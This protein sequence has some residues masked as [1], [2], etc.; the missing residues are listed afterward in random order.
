M[1]LGDSA[2]Q[3]APPPETWLLRLPELAEAD[4]Q[5]RFR[6]RFVSLECLVGTAE[7]PVYLTIAE[8]RVTEA[9]RGPLLMRPWRFA[10]RATPRAW[11]AFWQ[12]VPCPGWHDLFALTKRGE[13]TIEGEIGPLL[14]N[15]Q[16]FKDLLALPRGHADGWRVVQEGSA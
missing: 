1:T 2:E 15:L 10:I 4:E 16:Y 3:A 13:A 8:G 7:V 14:A 9:K 5:L 11:H 6:G 12:P